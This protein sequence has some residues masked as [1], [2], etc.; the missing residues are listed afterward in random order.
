MKRTY[1]LVILLLICI[2]AFENF[3]CTTTK[4]PDKLVNGN[5]GPNVNSTEDDYLP[6]QNDGILYFTSRRNAEKEEIFRAKFRNKGLLNQAVKDTKLPLYTYSNYGTIEFFTDPK[7]MLT[8]LYFTASPPKNKSDRNIYSSTFSDGKWSK[9]SELTGDINSDSYESHPAIAPDGSFMI[10]SS[11]REG[12]L[13]ETDLFVSLL[14]SDGTWGK[15]KNLGNKINS[16]YQEITPYIADDLSLYYSS[17]SYSNGENYDLA[18]CKYLGNYKWA[19]PEFLMSP[20][21]SESDEISPIIYE[22][23]IYFASNRKGGCGCY[24][25]YAMELF[26]PVVIEGKIIT[27]ELGIKPDG[28]V[29]LFT[30]DEVYINEFKVTSDGYYRF[31]AKPNTNYTI[32]YNNECLK[33]FRQTKFLNTESSESKVLKYIVNFNLPE[34]LRLFT[35]EK[36]KVPFF[37]SGYYFPNTRENLNTLRLRFQYGLIGNNDSTKYIENPGTEY[38]SYADSVNKALTEAVDFISTKLNFLSISCTN[39]NERMII[40]VTGYAD[41]RP[42]SDRARYDGVDIIE[43]KNNINIVR[44]ELMSNEMLSTLRA[45][46]TTRYL[47]TFLEKTTVYNNYSD[48][49]IWV[50]QGKGIDDSDAQPNEQRRK[51]KIEISVKS[52]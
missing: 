14:N 25:L 24:D 35:T 52:E 15:P 16:K 22:D 17:K 44:G 8:Q 9:P 27:G 6:K 11:D 40:T 43:P 34:N 20:I 12:S 5:L 1:R 47:R 13:G 36:Y 4:C 3:G 37:V 41:P 10:F 49:I 50:M 32:K 31:D 2:A 30:K 23:M 39:G 45:Y 21:N 42:L 28:V 38:D 18:K 7:T 26:G 29:Q 48:K 33:E 46:Y 19:A 51:V